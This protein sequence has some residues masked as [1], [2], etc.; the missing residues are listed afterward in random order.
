[1]SCYKSN[2]SEKLFSAEEVAALIEEFAKS[3]DMAYI[4]DSYYNGMAEAVAKHW[5]KKKLHIQPSETLD[6]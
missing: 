4:I 6:T 2:S 3:D 1:M 5:I